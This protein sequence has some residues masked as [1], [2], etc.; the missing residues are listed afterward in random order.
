MHFF[1]IFF[2][3][4]ENNVPNLF[5]FKDRGFLELNIL[6]TFPTIVQKEIGIKY[7]LSFIF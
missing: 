5:Y 3:D 2:E 1:E 7:F 4:R 6:H